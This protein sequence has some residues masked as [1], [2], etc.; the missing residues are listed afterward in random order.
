MNATSPT[1]P[2]G[3]AVEPFESEGRD[4]EPI[5]DDSGEDS[6]IIASVAR[7]C[8][9]SPDEVSEILLCAAEH[10][11][12]PVNPCSKIPDE[13]RKWRELTAILLKVIDYV[14]PS[15]KMR[16]DE[17]DALSTMRVRYF[18]VLHA[19]DKE[20][21]D[22]INGSLNPQQ[23]AATV[24]VLKCNFS[25]GKIKWTPKPLTKA[26]VNKAIMEAQDHFRL[27]PRRDQRS[28]ETREKQSNARNNQ[29]TKI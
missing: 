28:D 24:T 23:F 7:E 14:R 2:K 25:K 5:E 29:L 27:P 26:A 3:Y 10:D 11:L 20:Q 21:F 4:A 13:M 6:N 16:Q 22:I 1:N 12:K 19:F 15:A 9:C 17:Y 8:G 18:A